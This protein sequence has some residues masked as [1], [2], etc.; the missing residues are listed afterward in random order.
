MAETLL[1]PWHRPD[2]V[3]D[4]CR[5]PGSPY[6]RDLFLQVDRDARGRWWD[7]KLTTC[8]LYRTATT[9]SPIGTQLPLPVL[10]QVDRFSLLRLCR[11][12]Y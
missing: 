9:T 4:E 6:R 2:H 10:I 7:D 3:A 12:G 5:K 8:A 11:T 1:P